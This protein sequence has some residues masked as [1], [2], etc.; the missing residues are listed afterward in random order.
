MKI[1]LVK[2]IFLLSFIFFSTLNAF[3]QDKVV[4]DR[5]VANVGDKIILQ[6]DI[7]NQVLQFIAQG[8]PAQSGVECQLLQQLLTQKLLLIQAYARGEQ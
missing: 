3:S 6:S 2:Q 8:Y 4:I 1:N 7:E 5:V